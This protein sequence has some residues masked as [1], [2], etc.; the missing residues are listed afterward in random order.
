[1]SLRLKASRRDAERKKPSHLGLITLVSRVGDK[2][3]SNLIAK[4]LC[5]SLCAGLSFAKM[6]SPDHGITD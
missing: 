2:V 3:S 1:M 6:S 5:A 4:K